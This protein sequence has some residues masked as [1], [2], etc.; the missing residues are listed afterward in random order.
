MCHEYLGPCGYSWMVPLVL[1]LLLLLL[2]VCCDWS[3]CFGFV[4]CRS[5][6]RCWC[7]DVGHRTFWMVFFVK[8]CCG[9]VGGSTRYIA[10]ECNT[11]FV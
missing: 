9:G 1:V 3:Q 4:I 11:R 2:I 6:C 8:S 7:E 10:L 5:H